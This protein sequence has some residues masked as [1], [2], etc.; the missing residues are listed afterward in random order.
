MSSLPD[1]QTFQATGYDRPPSFELE[2]S[3]AIPAALIDQARSDASAVGYLHGWAQGV[4]EAQQAQLAELEATRAEHARRRAVRDHELA[5]AIGAM[6]AAA[7][8]LEAAAAP[9]AADIENQIVSAAVHLAEALLGHE[10]RSPE[11]AATSALA[12]VLNL[13]P[14]D[15]PISISLSPGDHAILT[16]D[17]GAAL[18]AGLPNTG[19]R[20]IVLLADPTLACGEAVARCGATSIDARLS[21]ALARLTEYVNR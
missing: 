2:A 15:E 17:G 18:I 16:G 3:S 1:T 9:H 8:Q 21:G 4:R 19:A 20:D 14:L 10:L 13:A 7:G 5:S 11:L 6:H 12:R